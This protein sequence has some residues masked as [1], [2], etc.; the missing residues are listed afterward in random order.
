M[1]GTI[2]FDQPEQAYRGMVLLPFAGRIFVCLGH[3]WI[4]VDR[5]HNL[6]QAKAM[7]HRQHMVGKNFPGMF[8]DDGGAQDQPARG[9]RLA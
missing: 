1:L 3:V 8:A 5:C 6:V 4:S 9:F 7:F 2:V